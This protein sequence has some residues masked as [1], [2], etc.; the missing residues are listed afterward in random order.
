MACPR[1]TIVC[2]PKCSTTNSNTM[3]DF[4]THNAGTDGTVDIYIRTD[5]GTVSATIVTPTAYAL[6]GRGTTSLMCSVMSAMAT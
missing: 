6:M 1:P 4:G 2:S 5:A 3:F